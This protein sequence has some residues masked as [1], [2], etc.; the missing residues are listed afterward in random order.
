MF[1]AFALLLNL[2]DSR[3]AHTRDHGKMAAPYPQVVLFGDSLFQAASGLQEGFSFQAALQLH[4]IRRF[5]VVNRGF[6]GYNTSQ[7]LKA[8][9]DVFPAPSPQ[10][11]KIAY[12]FVLLGAND[13]ALYMEEE[14]QHVDLDAFTANLRNIITHPHIT[15]HK[16][17]VVL[18]TP[19][20][21]DE[22]RFAKEDLEKG[23]PYVT[24]HAK[25]SASYAEA[26]RKVA[27]EVDGVVLV[28]LWKAVMDVAVANTPGFDASSGLLGDPSSGQSGYLEELLPD[29]LHMN[30]K[31]YKIFFDAIAPHIPENPSPTNEDYIFPDWRVAPWLE[32]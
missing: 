26:V 19:P 20:P 30:G 22:I 5:D 31:A 1:L 14:N 16:P 4:C 25:I 13:A 3:Q 2:S 29:G 11:P 8:L 9:P 27:G 10:G 6:S 21:L 32:G 7:A 28:D 23:K 12:F 15:G 18:V 17:H 24:R